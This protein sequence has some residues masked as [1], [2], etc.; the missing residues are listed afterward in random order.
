MVNIYVVTGSEDGILGAGTNKKEALEAAKKYVLQC[1][2]NQDK[3][4]NESDLEIKESVVGIIV[5]KSERASVYAEVEI[6]ESNQYY[7]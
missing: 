5:V 1:L 7:Y 3:F 2:E 6:F 4:V